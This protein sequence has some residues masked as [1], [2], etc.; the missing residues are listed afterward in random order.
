MTSNI[1]AVFLLSAF[2]FLFWAGRY[3]QNTLTITPS[4]TLYVLGGMLLTLP[5]AYAPLAGFPL[6]AWRVAGLIAGLLFLFSCLQF[7]YSRRTLSLLLYTTLLLVFIQALEA[8]LQLFAP[9]WSLAPLYGKRAYG[10]FFQPNVLAS[11]IATGL[12]LVL[13]LF[14]LPLFALP[15]HEHLRKGGLLILLVFFSALLVWLQS[16]VGWLGGGVAAILFLCR[17]GPRFPKR[18]TTAA[19]CMLGGGLLALAVWQCADGMVTTIPHTQSNQARWTMLNDTLSMIAQKPMLGWGYGSFEYDFQHFRIN[20]HPPTP[21]TEIASHPHNEILLW[22]VEGGMLAFVGI[23]VMALGYIQTVLRVFRHDKQAFATGQSHAGLP[24]ALMF[25]QMPILLHTQ[26]EYPFYLSA[27][28]FVVFLLF[29]AIADQLSDEAISQRRLSPRHTSALSGVM[30]V[31]ALGLTIVMGYAF[32]GKEAI[33][34]VETYRMADITPLQT[35]PALS[36]WVLRERV[37]FDENVHAL[38][39]FNHSRDEQA[40]TR[41]RHWAQAYLKQHIDKNVYANL[42]IILQHQHCG[43]M[44]EQYRQDAARFFPDDKRFAAVSSPAKET[45]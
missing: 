32:K 21:I 16:R 31:L 7:R 24:T 28:H 11:F 44:A 20:Q 34:Q 5:L 29:I 2:L 27:L 45:Q 30:S 37:T 17:F 42:I 10:F 13:M 12:S 18:G 25:A 9:T 19:V 33:A 36:R 39:M 38:L 15:R 4:Y 6:G 35:L 40:L 22:V 41:Y 14:L 26:L 1:I 3:S 43:T 23:G 8:I